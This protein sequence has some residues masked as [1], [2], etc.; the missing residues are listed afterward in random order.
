MYH[1]SSEAPDLFSNTR[2]ATP[3]LSEPE[4]QTIDRARISVGD[5]VRSLNYRVRYEL[6]RIIGWSR[7]AVRETPA[8]NLPELS[9]IQRRRVISL[10]ARYHVR[11]E[12]RYQ[13]DTAVRNYAYLDVLDRAREELDWRVPQ[14]NTVYD[15]GSATFSYAPSLQA[16][17][18]PRRLVGVEIDAYRL[19]HHWRSRL[20]LA[21][22]YAKDLPHTEYLVADYRALRFTADVIL[23]WYPFVT[24]KRLLA[25]RLPLAL[26]EPAKL[27]EQVFRNLAT[28]GT[29]VMVNCSAD[30]MQV[31]RQGAIRAGL[32]CL[33]QYLHR[34]PLKARS[35]P[36]ILTI[37]KRAD[38][39]TPPVLSSV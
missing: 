20:D 19:Y 13:K 38:R 22:G 11:F 3:S 31:A 8:E 28:D 39:Q 37:W 27:F 4:P 24:P 9:P 25:W 26:F 32:H 36:A 35:Q 23:A 17:F 18:K 2:A 21:R 34:E 14:G 16:F 5:R 33:G 10:I 15:L 12:H 1:E 29:F 6:S 7:G 30:E